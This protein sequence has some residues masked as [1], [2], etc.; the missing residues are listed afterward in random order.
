MRKTTRQTISLGLLWLTLIWCAVPLAHAEDEP[1]V[2][3]DKIIVTA[4]RTDSIS[5]TPNS[6]ATVAVPDSAPLSSNASELVGRVSGVHILSHGGLEAATSVSIRGSSNAQVE[7]Y[8]DD[9]PIQ[10]AGNEGIGL[11]HIAAD[12]LAR[13]QVYKSFAPIDLGTDA[14]GGVIRL[15]SRPIAKGWHQKDDAGF[16]SFTTV[17]GTSEISHGGDNANFLF[18]VNYRRTSGDFKFLDDN[19]TPLNPNDDQTVTRQNNAT[20]VIHPYIKW[21]DHLDTRTTLT[22]ASHFFRVDSGVPGLQ[23]F[24]SQTADRSLTEWMGQVKV[25]RTGVFHG[26][27]WW[28]DVAYWRLIKSQFSDQNGEIGLGAGQDN[29]DH[30]VVLGNRMFVAWTPWDALV[31]KPGADYVVESFTPRDYFAAN[32]FGTTSTR[33]QFGVF[34][35]PNASLWDGLLAIDSQLRLLNVFYKINNDDPSLAGRG[36]FFSNRTEHPFLGNIAAMFRVLPGFFVKASG[37][38]AVRL[39]KF[40]ELFGDQ[41]TVLGNPQLTSEKSFKG[42]GGV[43]WKKDFAGF[44]GKTHIEL[45]YFESHVTD[46]IQFELA[47]GVARA[48]NL[49]KARIRGVEFNGGVKFLKHFE[50]TQNYTWQHA[51]DEA[52]HPGNFLVGRPEHEFNTGLSFDQKPVH[53]ATSFNFI[54]NQYLDSLNTQKINNRLRWDAELTYS[55][56]KNYLVGLELKNITGTQIVDAIGFPLPGQSVFGRVE[57]RF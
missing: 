55:F 36:T 23:S 47:N 7:V 8:L 37:G 39:P 42:D 49:G 19:G 32:S 40:A 52:T 13:I 53:V 6:P 28:Q 41:G 50:F 5:E 14:I 34:I 18:N 30:T 16:G 27:L 3:I 1:I 48:N 24:Q 44:I 12:G 4:P 35:E 22:L 43:M 26:R 46:L 21:E 45:N 9:I 29:D 38:R 10:T 17:F 20:Q 33:Q 31:V 56:R 2:E 11:E 25:K 57:A 54:D 15:E 51:Q